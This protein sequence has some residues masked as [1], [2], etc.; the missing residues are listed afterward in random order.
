MTEQGKTIFFKKYENTGA[1]ASGATERMAITENDKYRYG[2]FNVYKVYNLSTQDI[3]IR[4][5]LSNQKA[6]VVPS[7]SGSQLDWR[8]NLYFYE[9]EIYNRGAVAIGANEIIVEISK[10]IPK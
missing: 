9:I 7:G 3:E 4:L 2:A 5:G 1:V 8:E 6:D 10:I